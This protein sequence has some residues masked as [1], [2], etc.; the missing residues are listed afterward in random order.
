M[1]EHD[2]VERP[3]A[4]LAPGHDTK[5]DAAS[6]CLLSMVLGS[7]LIL[8]LVLGIYWGLNR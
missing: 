1:S 6:G 2:N 4:F 7:V 8:I 5:T 3:G